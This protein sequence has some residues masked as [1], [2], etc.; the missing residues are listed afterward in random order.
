MKFHID[1][2][3][4][5][6]MLL[7]LVI[8]NVASQDEQYGLRFKSY[9]TYKEN[10]TSLNLTPNKPL[11]LP[12]QYTISFDLKFNQA[13]VH[14]FG[15]ILRIIS[16]DKK[17]IDLL[18][19]EKRVLI[20]S[21]TESS[22][23]TFEE[24]GIT[25]DEWFHVDLFFD[26]KENRISAF[27]GNQKIAKII[28]DLEHFNKVSLIFGKSDYPG[29][30]Y[31]DIPPMSVKDIK[32]A[33]EKQKTLYQWKLSKHTSDG[34][35]DEIKNHLAL[36][37]NPIW[38]IDD[39]VYWN[40]LYS[41]TTKPRPQM[42]YNPD[43]NEIFVYDQESFYRFDVDSGQLIKNKAENNN[44]IEV[45]SNNLIY[46]PLIKNYQRYVLDVDKEK[47]VLIFDSLF[48]KWD[49]VSMSPHSPAFW[50]H[51]RYISPT[52]NSLYLFGG[53]GYYT[54]HNHFRIYNFNNNSWKK[55]EVLSDSIYPRYLSGLGKVDDNYLLIFGGYG[56]HTGNQELS[57]QFYY[58]L[59][60]VN[61]N[62]MLSKKR[63][64]LP[65]PSEDFVVANSLIVDT[66]KKSFYALSFSTQ[67]F[68]TKLSLL[69]FSIDK[70]EYSIVADS[71]PVNF[72]DT[73]SY[74][75]LFL[76]QE[77]QQ[78][79]AI[80]SFPQQIDDTLNT[81]S[82]Y[83]LSYPPLSK[84]D[85]IQHIAKPNNNPINFIVI[86]FVVIIILTVLFALF[87][88]QRRNRKNSPSEL[89]T[90]IKE[91]EENLA[92]PLTKEKANN[93]VY[94]LGGFCVIDKEGN[95]ITKEFTPTLKQ[96]F[97]LILLYTYKDRKGILTTKLNEI[98][99]FD[100]SNESAK[101]NRGVSIRRLRQIFEQSVGVSIISN[102]SYWSVDWD[103]ETYCD[104]IQSL[105]LMD[106]LSKST[107][108]SMEDVNNLLSIV[109][110]GELLPNLQIEWVDSFKSDF[111][112][113]L[114]DLLLNLSKYPDIKSSPQISINLADAIFIHDSLNEDAL[115]LKCSILLQ[116][117]RNS[118]S[119][120][121]YTAF[122]KEYKIV[123]GEEYGYS[124]DKIV[125]T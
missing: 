61:L 9:D 85:I 90:P 95:D 101:N 22:E 20:N 83:T 6:F 89:L 17:H 118:L 56:S 124:F 114:I 84:N 77:S 102:N 57:T 19:N 51:N 110:V 3:L 78:L 13:D 105:Y 125:N 11:T 103:K 75:D 107:Q 16:E 41:F 15:Y 69:Q 21:A 106:K 39:H 25:Y 31:T 42:D 35:F 91:W 32:I 99:W 109:S 94:L 23:T 108:I 58:D 81:I 74:F 43:K 34:V 24:A 14:Q 46:N 60:E 28:P 5:P 117:G 64:T 8:Q 98:L 113:T 44:P 119:K 26:R 55:Q 53:Y 104:Y 76:D 70:P 50:H 59:Y 33:D 27:I 66:V 48:Y 30:Q 45:Q 116:M 82:V 67:K 10:R 62:T 97:I 1:N 73:F 80:T 49:R 2:F 65:T 122:A 87:Y 12:E 86:L 93:S 88:R 37:E 40:K 54:Y 52:D 36:C 72:D 115:R 112:N 68:E 79:I 111:A 123:F 120:K 4:L 71:I 121:V 29:L 38:I 63:W 92:N 100:K 96:L 7:F 47:E 18:Q